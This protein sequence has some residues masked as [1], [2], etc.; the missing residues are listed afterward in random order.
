MTFVDVPA[1]I[2]DTTGVKANFD[3]SINASFTLHLPWQVYSDSIVP[4][5]NRLLAVLILETVVSDVSILTSGEEPSTTLISTLV[6]AFLF[7]ASRTIRR[8]L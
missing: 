2:F 8:S 1:L 7:A 6:D 5:S 3:R 4:V